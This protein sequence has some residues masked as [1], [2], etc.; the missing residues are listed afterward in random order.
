MECFV[1][2]VPTIVL[3]GHSLNLVQPFRRAGKNKLMAVS[4]KQ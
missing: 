3:S 2:V 1:G 4:A